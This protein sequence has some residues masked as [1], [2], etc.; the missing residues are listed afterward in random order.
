M[1]KRNKGEKADT[2]TSQVQLF[3]NPVD[4]MV[5]GAR[6]IIGEE[7]YVVGTVE[8]IPGLF[9]KIDHLEVV[10]NASEC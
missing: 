2:I 4:E 5:V 7:N 6:V 9:G 1:N 3:C 10:L 8:P